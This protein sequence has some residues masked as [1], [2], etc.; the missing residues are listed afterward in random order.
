MEDG[1]ISLSEYQ[2]WNRIA[3]RSN[4]GQSGESTK[5]QVMRFLISARWLEGQAAQQ[6]I[7]ATP[8]QIKT[9]LT[10]QSRSAFKTEQQ[11]KQFLTKTGMTENDLLFRAKLNLLA[12]K[13]RAQASSKPVSVSSQEIMR[14]YKENLPRFGAAAS[15]DVLI[16]RTNDSLRA[17]TAKARIAEGASFSKMAALYSDDPGSKAHGGMLRVAQDGFIGKALEAAVFAAP[18]GKLV[19]PLRVP[20]PTVPKKALYYVFQVQKDIASA[21]QSPQQAKPAIVQLL[22]SQKKRQQIS[23]FLNRLEKEWKPRTSCQEG[24]VISSCSNFSKSEQE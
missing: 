5:Q 16:I 6:D 21:R 22:K 24:Y 7:Q 15:R 2:A 1:K 8:S 13:L 23:D 20:Y 14:F 11:K 4:P 3:S 10:L 9:A 12:S 18:V 19:G 17:Q